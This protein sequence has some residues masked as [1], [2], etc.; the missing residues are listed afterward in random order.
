MLTLG[1]AARI[2]PRFGT[3]RLQA[4]PAL[5]LLWTASIRHRSH[6][7]GSGLHRVPCKA[8]GRAR[9]ARSAGVCRGMPTHPSKRDLCKRNPSFDCRQFAAAVRSAPGVTQ[10]AAQVHRAWGACAWSGGADARPAG[11]TAGRS[12]TCTGRA[13]FLVMH[14]ACLQMLHWR[15]TA[16]WRGSDRCFSAAAALG[17]KLAVPPRQC[18]LAQARPTPVPSRKCH[19]LLS[20]TCSLGMSMCRY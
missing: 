6:G 5:A 8:H 19:P 20:G 1:K 13:A 4:L 18:L 15:Y 2:A 10:C 3:G 17:S 12:W 9:A 16:G 14:V 11:S 7:C